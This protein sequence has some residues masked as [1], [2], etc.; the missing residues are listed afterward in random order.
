MEEVRLPLS[1]AERKLLC[2]DVVAMP[3]SFISRIQMTPPDV[4]V[5]FRLWELND[6]LGC[7]GIAME[8]ITT[9]A[10]QILEAGE[11][12]DVSL[13]WQTVHAAPIVPPALKPVKRPRPDAGRATTTKSR[14]RPVH[15][16]VADRPADRWTQSTIP[17]NR[18]ICQDRL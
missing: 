5:P 6:L 18:L 12:M 2:H 7:V 1:T 4:G 14:S 15:K 8:P 3:N 17:S 10:N 16:A 11:F 9:N 13:H